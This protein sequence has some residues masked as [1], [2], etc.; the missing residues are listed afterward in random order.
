MSV[1]RVQAMGRVACGVGY[2][3]SFHS[4][5]Q[6]KEDY[7]RKYASSPDGRNR[8]PKPLLHSSFH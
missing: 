6:K 8:P 3:D 5:M 4:V 7:N 2:E 1:E